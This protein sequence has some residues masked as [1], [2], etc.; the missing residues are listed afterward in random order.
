MTVGLVPQ[1]LVPVGFPLTISLSY[2]LKEGGSCQISHPLVL[3]QHPTEWDG[4]L[5]VTYSLRDILRLS[6]TLLTPV[7]TRLFVQAEVPASILKYRSAHS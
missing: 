2:R 6:F 4:E 5:P 3:G 7:L 1:T